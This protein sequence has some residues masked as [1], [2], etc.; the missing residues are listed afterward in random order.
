MQ[1]HNVCGNKTEICFD[2]TSTAT[3]T[4]TTTTTN[5]TADVTIEGDCAKAR[6]ARDGMHWCMDEVGGRINGGLSCLLKCLQYSHPDDDWMKLRGCEE[7]CNEQYMSLKPVVP[8][9]Y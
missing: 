7:S 1:F 9:K 3:T 5:S 6:Y 4:T 8:G 2:T